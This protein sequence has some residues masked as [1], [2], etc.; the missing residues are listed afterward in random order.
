MAPLCNDHYYGTYGR[1]FCWTKRNTTRNT[2]G[3]FAVGAKECD[4]EHR[5]GVCC[6]GNLTDYGRY[7]RASIRRCAPGYGRSVLRAIRCHPVAPIAPDRCPRTVP[8]STGRG[9]V[10]RPGRVLLLDSFT[11]VVP[12]GNSRSA[13][14][15]GGVVSVFTRSFNVLEA[16]GVCTGSTVQGKHR[17]VVCCGCLKFLIRPSIATVH[18]SDIYRAIPTWIPPIAEVTF[19]RP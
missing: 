15:R 17:A 12:I 10:P 18:H 7:R 4:S 1:T 14:S 2:G 9:I 11:T 19:R 5:R 8:P 13:S 16:G 6:W 3:V